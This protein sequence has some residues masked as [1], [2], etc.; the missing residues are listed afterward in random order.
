MAASGGDQS[1][2]N[3]ILGIKAEKTSTTTTIEATE[4]S[5]MPSFSV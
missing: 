3:E 5:F 2:L 4:I 1:R